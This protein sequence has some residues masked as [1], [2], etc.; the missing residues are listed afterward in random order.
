MSKCLSNLLLH[1][2]VSEQSTA[3]CQSVWAI[4]CCMSK[5]LSDLL[6]F[7]KV[8]ERS[9]AVC[10]SVWAIYCCLLKC[11]SDLLL[12]VKVHERSTAV[13]QSAWAIYRCVSKC[14][15]DLP[16]YVKTSVLYVSVWA[17]YCCT[18]VSERPTVVCQRGCTFYCGMSKCI[19]IV[20][21]T[22]VSW[23]LLSC[24]V[25]ARSTAVSQCHYVQLLWI[26]LSIDAF[27]CCCYVKVSEWST[28]VIY[29]L[30]SLLLFV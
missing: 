9:T 7:V 8:S 27:Y 18:S 3:V 22:V 10:Q 19:Y 29:H 26:K 5:C 6:L 11:L 24:Q 12:Y 23:C 14:M 28:V 2:K 20:T 13:C 4:Y 1:V 25:F 17:I 16:L 21:H 15:S 30:L